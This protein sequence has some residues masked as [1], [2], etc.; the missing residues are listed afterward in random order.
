MER[1]GTEALVDLI[2]EAAVVPGL[3]P[4]TLERIATATNSLGGLLFAVNAA[5]QGS[6]VASKHIAPLMQKFV[7][8]D[9]ARHNVRPARGLAAQYFGFMA[10]LDVMTAEE[11]EHDLIY[12]EILRPGGVAWTCGAVVSTPNGDLLVFDFDRSPRAGPFDRKTLSFL[13]SLRPH[14]ARAGVLASHLNLQRARAATATLDALGLP[15]AVLGQNGRVISAN[16]RLEIMESQIQI[17]A[18]DRIS[19]VHASSDDL[20][21]QALAHITDDSSVRSIPVPATDDAPALIV[22]IVPIRRQAHDVLAGATSLLVVTDLTTPIAPHVGLLCG[23]FDL[24][25]SEARVASLLAGGSDVGNCAGALGVSRETVRTQ[26]KS[27][28][29]KT[30]TS[31]QAELIGLLS[32]IRQFPADK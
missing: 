4:T 32:R 25:P 28:M 26:L 30:G 7:E 31:R 12:R 1:V 6:W 20:M 24:T 9:Y 16:P 15:G 18:F 14:L 5:Q 27:V 10:D 21:K 23:L 22:H 29:A 2:Y 19:L 3:W 8:G 17:R 13:D 11:I